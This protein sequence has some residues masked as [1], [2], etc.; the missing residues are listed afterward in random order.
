MTTQETDEAKKEREAEEAATAAKEERAA[1]IAALKAK[2]EEE[3]AAAE[4]AAH[5]VGEEPELSEVDKKFAYLTKIIEDQAKQID[6]LIKVS[7][8]A[9]LASYEEKNPKAFS[10]KVLVSTYQGKFVTGWHMVM[11]NVYKDA[12]DNTH[13]EQ[14]VEI[15]V[16]GESDP[17]TMAYRD[18]AVNKIQKVSAVVVK[19]ARFSEDDV[20]REVLTVRVEDKISSLNGKE[21]EL[22]TRFIN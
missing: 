14:V 18:Y 10:P 2:K 22:D 8:K 20:E 7:D 1:K 4:T 21:I 16:E 6:M 11:N 15:T 12:N 13:V 5:A 17:I 9:R 19:R 3:A